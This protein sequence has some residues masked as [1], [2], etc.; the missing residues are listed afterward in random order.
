MNIRTPRDTL[1]VDDGQT[2]NV[3]GEK[4]F[5]TQNNHFVSKLARSVV[6]MITDDMS[7]EYAFIITQLA[8]IWTW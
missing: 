8:E 1:D 7:V 4:H 3:I 6:A 2:K 5:E